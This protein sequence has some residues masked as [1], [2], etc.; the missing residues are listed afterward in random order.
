MV[1]SASS[2]PHASSDPSRPSAVGEQHKLVFI[3]GLHRSGTSLLHRCLGDHP[4]TSVF[5]DTGAVE[6][7]GQLLQS[8]YPPASAYGGP[9]RFALDPEAHLTE[10]SPLATAAHAQELLAQWTPYWDLHKPVLVEKSP[11]NLIRLRFLQ[12]LYP[13]AYFIVLIRHPLAVSF[14]TTKWRDMRLDQLVRHWVVS[15]KRFEA[16][17]PAVRRLCVLR[18]EDFVAHPEPTLH[19]L[20]RFLGL[21]PHPLA[22]EVRSAVNDKYFTWYEQMQQHDLL[23][24]A[25]IAYLRARFERRARSYGYS[26]TPSRYVLP[27][28]KSLQTISS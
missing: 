9:G 4:A 18:Y 3:G 2:R 12:A 17:R 7:E 5:E 15:H 19:A 25:Y 8:V 27:A 21:H 6:D 28:P 23:R 14:A 13:D 20:H 24:R 10:A 16:D 26:L 1:N 22:R 11:P